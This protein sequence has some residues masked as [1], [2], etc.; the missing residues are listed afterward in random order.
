[1]DPQSAELALLVAAVSV[2]V[3]TRLHHR[4]LGN[5]IDVAAAAAITL[6][7][8]KD[9]LVP[10]LGG[11]PTLDSWHGSAPL[12]VRQHGLH[13]VRIGAMDSG[14]PAQMALV[15]GGLLGEDVALER[16]RALD[17]AAP[18]HAEALFCAALGFH[19]W[20]DNFSF[21]LFAAH[22]GALRGRGLFARGQFGRGLT[23][24]GPVRVMLRSNGLFRG[25][26][27]HHWPAFEPWKLSDD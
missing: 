21:V 13:R 18:A 1:R 12:G 14:G 2:L 16:L 7:E 10:R 15:L 26:H 3:L 20:H 9:L 17:A 8:G 27:H 4:F 6:R 23:G 22:R 19:L 25:Q 11:H 24:F 5:A